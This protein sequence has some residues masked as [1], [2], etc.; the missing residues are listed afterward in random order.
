VLA[1]RGAT[2]FAKVTVSG[3][4]VFFR[5]LQRVDSWHQPLLY[6]V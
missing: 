6:A 5:L 3:S 4:P 1:L 2:S